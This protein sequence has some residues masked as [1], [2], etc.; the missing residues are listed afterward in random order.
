MAKHQQKLGMKVRTSNL[1]SEIMLHTGLDHH[2]KDRT[3]VCCLSSVNLEKWDEWS[4]EINFIE[5]IMRF[6]DNVLD[7]FIDNAPDS[8][9]KMQFTQLKWKDQL[10]LSYGLS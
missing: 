1:C 10:V 5:D 3:A 2:G 9:K 8:M 7:D 6:L 4:G